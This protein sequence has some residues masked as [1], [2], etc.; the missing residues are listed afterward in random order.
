[1]FIRQ[2]HFVKVCILLLWL[3]QQLA[4]PLKGEGCFREGVQILLK[5]LLQ[6]WEGLMVG[7]WP[8]RSNLQEV[9]VQH[10]LTEAY[11][12]MAAASRVHSIPQHDWKRQSL[13]KQNPGREAREASAEA[14]D[15]C[16]TS[17]LLVSGLKAG[18][19]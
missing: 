9:Y 16:R 12:R 13:A 7:K 14:K 19:I 6:V 4:Q 10:D 5:P 15:T 3:H 18:T 1:M 2:Y 8:W 17:I 11:K